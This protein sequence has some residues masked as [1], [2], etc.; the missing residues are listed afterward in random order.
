MDLSEEIIQRLTRIESLL[1]NESPRQPKD[2]YSVREAAD[3]LNKST[4]TVR[5]WCRLG[6]VNAKKTKA[7]RGRYS[8]WIVSQ[9]ELVR[10]RNE[11]LLPRSK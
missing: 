6:R 1:V 10:I 8:E 9:E 2:W 4:F 3:L 11:G 7:G 5:E